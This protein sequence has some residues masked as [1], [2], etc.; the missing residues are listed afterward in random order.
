[1]SQRSVRKHAVQ[2]HQ[3]AVDRLQV[4]IFAAEQG[5]DVSIGMLELA[6]E[7]LHAGFAHELRSLAQ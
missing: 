1:M 2:E 3:I 5:L 7:A 6:L 4:G